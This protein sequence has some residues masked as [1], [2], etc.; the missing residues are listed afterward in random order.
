MQIDVGSHIAGLLYEHNSVNIPGLGGFV[1]RYQPAVADQVQGQVHPPSKGLAF[2]GNLV[3]DDGLLAQ[4]LHEK[5]GIT[6]AEAKEAVDAYVKEVKAAIEKR[7]IVVFPKVGRLYKDYEQ[8]LQFLADT[9][10]F[11]LD[12]YGLPTVH[13]YPIARKAEQGSSVRPANGQPRPTAGKAAAPKKGR[14]LNNGLAIAI[15]LA[16]IIVAVAAY[17]LFFRTPKPGG[18]N[19]ERMPTS[20]INISPSQAEGQPAAPPAELPEDAEDGQEEGAYPDEDT[21]DGEGLDTEGAT[22]APGQKYFIIGIG[23]F[24]N[25]NNVQRL[26]ERIYQAGYEPYT[27]PKGNLTRVGIQKAYTDESEVRETLQD[28]RRRFSKDAKVLRK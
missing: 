4:H 12:S 14:F 6:L 26:I 18:D 21:A 13:F 28:V 19:P 7:E 20:R 16:L 15:S 17:F 3:A 10:N 23:V 25:E 24:G 11:N 27:E 5:L 9:T 1:S 2:N 22:A 8:N